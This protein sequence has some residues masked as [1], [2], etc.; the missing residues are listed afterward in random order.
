MTD[1]HLPTPR[2]SSSWDLE[3]S[4][5]RSFSM[6]VQAST[7]I[8]SVQ[9]HERQWMQYLK[10]LI[11][12]IKHQ[13]TSGEELDLSLNSEADNLEALSEAVSARSIARGFVL[14][15]SEIGGLSRELKEA[16]VREEQ[17][18]L[19]LTSHQQQIHKL[20][21]QY[22]ELKEQLQAT[23][24]FS[25]LTT[26]RDS[27][28]TISFSGASAARSE[29]REQERRLQEETKAEQTRLQGL[30]EKL[31]TDLITAR[32]D[33]ADARRQGTVAVTR[34]KELERQLEEA[35]KTFESEM[36]ACAEEKRK[37]IDEAKAR[38][39]ALE[40]IAPEHGSGDGN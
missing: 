11:L 15:G 6:N 29:D 14:F 18:Q 28:P 12:S 30:V 32:T 3:A 17:K 16:E 2:S 35:G 37:A 25:R 40:A 31:Q 4:E 23:S 9:L 33:E 26:S 5:L 19:Q 1:I 39:I 7:R 20:S 38:E 24:S 22:R 10:R 13:E 21:T 36:L 27:L 34:A 8:D